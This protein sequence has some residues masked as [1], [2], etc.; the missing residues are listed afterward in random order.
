MGGGLVVFD[1]AVVLEYYIYLQS[2][3]SKRYFSN[4]PTYPTMPS[5]INFTLA[6]K[7]KPNF[8]SNPIAL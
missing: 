2:L 8:T 4:I 3:V 1:P 5:Y 7:R 6:P